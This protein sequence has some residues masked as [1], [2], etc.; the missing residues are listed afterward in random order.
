M[1]TAAFGVFCAVVLLGL[2]LVALQ[3]RPQGLGGA[4]P[5]AL[6]HGG[7]GAAGLAALAWALWGA[8]VAGGNAATSGAGSFGL[9]AVVLLGLALAIGV[10]LPLWFRRWG[11]S[12]GGG[13]IVLH[14]TIGF[15][16]FV[17]LAAFVGLR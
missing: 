10:S 11:G 8:R 2:G 1:L 9:D 3:S 16:G 12:A 4:W 5:L 6:V 7:L 15:T 13:V 17:L 14:A